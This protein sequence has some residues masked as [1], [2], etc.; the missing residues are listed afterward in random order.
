MDVGTSPGQHL[1]HQMLAANCLKQ[2]TQDRAGRDGG[3]S[4]PRLGAN[5][6]AKKAGT[7]NSPNRFRRRI[8]S[9]M[10]R[11]QRSSSH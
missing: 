1:G 5:G 9:R 7:A 4:L 6:R 3:Y 10:R 8:G 11:K 2:V